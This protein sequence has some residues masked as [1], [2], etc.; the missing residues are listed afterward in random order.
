MNQSE[1]VALSPKVALGDLHKQLAA[2]YLNKQV[3]PG[4]LYK[5]DQTAYQLCQENSSGH[6]DDTELWKIFRM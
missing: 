2:S 3:A 6:F 5:Q 4:Y 1:S